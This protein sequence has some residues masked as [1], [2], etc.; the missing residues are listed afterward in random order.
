MKTLASKI[1]ISELQIV[2][3]NE[4]MLE[5]M[6]ELF[7]NTIHSV[8][9]KDYTRGQL[10]RWAPLHPDVAAWKQR[11][12]R[13]V[14]KVA[15]IENVIVG[16]SELTEDAHVDCMY[17]HKDY[18][19]KNVAGILLKELQQ[20]AEERNYEVL[21]TEASITAKPF[22]EKHGFSVMQIKKK[23]YNGK[24]FINYKMKKQL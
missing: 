17:V 14:C 7:Y 16:F 2:S 4:E 22:F 3:Y 24:E 19:R 5:D 8:S 20:I 11:L 13:N 10:D 18:Q 6:M 1:G 12:N 23:L 15:M 9:A 21:T